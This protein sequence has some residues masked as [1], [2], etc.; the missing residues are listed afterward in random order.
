ME[1]LLKDNRIKYVSRFANREHLEL[2]KE[3]QDPAPIMRHLSENNNPDEHCNN[4]GKEIP[5]T[6]MT[7][8]LAY[9]ARNIKKCEKCGDPFDIAALDDHIEKA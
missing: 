7:L 4:C 5:K 1:S 9:C 3:I 2:M 6:K 8:H